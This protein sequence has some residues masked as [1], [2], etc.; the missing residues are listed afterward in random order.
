M[1]HQRSAELLGDVERWLG[2]HGAGEGRS[3][4]PG[5]GPAEVIDQQED[6]MGARGGGGLHELLFGDR[7]HAARQRQRRKHPADHRRS[8]SGSGG[9]YLSCLLPAPAL[10]LLPLCHRST[11]RGRPRPV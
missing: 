2:G 8:G 5:V 3:A 10:L 11:T 6:D 7:Q 1:D 9:G 4:P